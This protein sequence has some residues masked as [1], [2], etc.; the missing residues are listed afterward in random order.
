MR[1]I[2]RQMIKEDIQKKMILQEMDMGLSQDVIQTLWNLIS[3]GIISWQL[4][5]SLMNSYW[6]AESFGQWRHHRV[7]QRR[8]SS[9]PTE[10]LSSH[11]RT[12]EPQFCRSAQGLWQSIQ[13][14]DIRTIFVSRVRRNQ[15]RT[16]TENTSIPHRSRQATDCFF[17]TVGTLLG[18]SGLLSLPSHPVEGAEPWTL[19]NQRP[20]EVRSSR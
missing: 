16:G 12:A 6:C 1:K 3:A 17:P 9:V 14:D 15:S 10:C 19:A 11:P 4:G 7:H 2:I 13:G 8:F 20:S 18:Y 5:K